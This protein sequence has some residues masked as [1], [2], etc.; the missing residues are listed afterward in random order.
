MRPGQTSDGRT[1]DIVARSSR[2]VVWAI[3]ALIC[4]PLMSDLR[5]VAQDPAADAD[6]GQNQDVQVLTRGPVHE[7]FALPVVHD[8]KP[9]NIGFLYGPRSG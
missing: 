1:R 7:A 3:V 6:P 8:P 2:Q 5:A 9:G 4:S